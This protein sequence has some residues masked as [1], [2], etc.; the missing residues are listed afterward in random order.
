MTYM[1]ILR[2]VFVL[3]ACIGTLWA[4]TGQL[5]TADE[6]LDRYKTAQGGVDAIKRVQSEIAHGEIEGTGLQGKAM[7]V[8]YSKPFKSLF[9]DSRPDGTEVTSGFDGTVSWSVDSKGASI[10]RD[11]PVESN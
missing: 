8:S 4:Q 11:T 3:L 1:R 7:F 6:V 5:K 9:K 2:L 10:D